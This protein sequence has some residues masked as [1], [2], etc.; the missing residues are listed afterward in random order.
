MATPDHA[1]E[2][3]IICRL[4]KLEKEEALSWQEKK[5]LTYSLWRFILL[6]EN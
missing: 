3:A 6:L 2:H 1:G 5:V 4:L